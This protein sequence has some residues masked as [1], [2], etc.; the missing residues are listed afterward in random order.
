MSTS[1]SSEAGI[2]MMK[3]RDREMAAGGIATLT[4]WR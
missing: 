2:V 3:R 1:R 4:R